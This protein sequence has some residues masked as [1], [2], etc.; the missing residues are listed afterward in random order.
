MVDI[1]SITEREAVILK[2]CGNDVELLTDVRQLLVAH[3][4]AATGLLASAS[5]GSIRHLDIQQATTSNPV[6]D[7]ENSETIG[8]YKLLQEIGSGG[9]G[10]VWLAEQLKPVRRRVALKLI[11][12]GM[13]T[14][15]VIARFEAERQALALM[16]HTN[17]AKVFE[18]GTTI[19]GRPYFVMEYVKGKPIT[20]F[21]DENHLS[22]PERL[23]LFEQVCNAVQHAHHKGIIH[24]D[25]KPNNVLVSAPDGKP[26][27]KVI[28]FGIAKAISQQLT[29]LTLFTMHD[30][31]MGTPQY[32]SPCLLYTSPSPRD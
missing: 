14:K 23:E 25:L 29:D 15:L 27:A 8:P 9:M 13:D 30:Q 21:A 24:R 18:A 4:A 28:D 6:R 7:F 22:I 12:P 3:E 32:M 2:E 11:K 20:V 5:E 1:A 19:N 10:Q 17:I 31:F 16:N 26:L